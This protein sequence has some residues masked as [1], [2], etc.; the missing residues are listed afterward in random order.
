VSFGCCEDL[1]QITP[2]MLRLWANL[3]L[4]SPGA[5]LLL[6]NRA[7]GAETAWRA[8]R[9]RL[10]A[11]GIEPGRLVMS[12]PDAADPG[13]LARWRD[14][15][16]ALDTFPCNAMLGTCDALWMGVPVVTLAGRAAP[17]RVGAGI[18]KDA[19]LPELIA[20]DGEQYLRIALALASDPARLAA[21]RSGLRAR[22]QASALLDAGGFARAM[23]SAYHRMW[24]AHAE[25]AA[26]A[27]NG[28]RR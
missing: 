18:L 15:D 11:L 22:L 2:E 4:A 24:R 17:S 16:I 1:A 9:E 27:E 13:A 12:V 26:P 20:R 8:V 6:H 14:V 5:R 10:G 3:L 7:L 28:D 25:G 19:G 23:E 21:L